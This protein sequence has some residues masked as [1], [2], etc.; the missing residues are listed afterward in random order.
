M[1]AELSS[2]RLVVKSPPGDCCEQMSPS[3][4][5]AS[6]TLVPQYSEVVGFCTI[7]GF[8]CKTYAFISVL[9][10]VLLGFEGSP[11]KNDYLVAPGVR[12]AHLVVVLE[13][14]GTCRHHTT[15][16]NDAAH[17]ARAERAILCARIIIEHCVLVSPSR[18]A[19]SLKPVHSQYYVS[20]AKA[21]WHTPVSSHFTGI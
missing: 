6:F 20:M 11:M 1:A 21:P 19:R 7:S 13:G 14:A 3:S 12:G 16:R 4:R 9:L 18:S 15:L 8:L 2:S 5:A 17:W 10:A